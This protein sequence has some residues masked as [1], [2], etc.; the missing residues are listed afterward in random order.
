MGVNVV[1]REGISFSHPARFML[2]GTMNPEEGDLRPQLLDRFALCVDMHGIADPRQRVA[3]V[4]RRVAYESDPEGFYGEWLPHEEQISDEIAQARAALKHVTYTQRDLYTIAQLT[5]SFKVDGHRADIVILKTGP[6]PRGLAGPAGDRRA[7][8]PAGGRAGAAASPQAPTV[9][10]GGARCRPARRPAEEGPRRSAAQQSAP[11]RQPGTDLGIRKKS[12]EPLAEPSDASASGEPQEQDAGQAQASNTGP[13]AGRQV[14]VGADFQ[15]KRLDTPLDKL[16]RK[17]AGKRS[18]TLTERKRGRYIRSRPMVGRPEDL[19]FDATFRT[20]A[21]FQRR[22]S[23]ERAERKLAFVVKRQDFQ[24]K[25]RVRRSANLVLFVVDASWS[26]AAAE[27]M[28]AT[29]GAILS[30]LHDAYQRRDQVGLVVF[31][32]EE[33]RVV[34]APTS[35]VELAQQH[36]RNIPVGGKTPLS[37]GLLAAYRVCIASQRR[38]P[39]IAPVDHHPDRR[40]RQRLRHR[41]AAAAGGGQGRADDAR[42]PSAHGRHQ[43]GASRV[44]SRPGARAGER[45]GRPLLHAAGAEGRDTGADGAPGVEQQTGRGVGTARFCLT[46]CNRQPSTRRHPGRVRIRSAAVAA[47]A[48][49]S[50]RATERKQAH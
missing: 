34:L 40:R 21:P 25:V 41:D 43:H 29:K 23:S 31:Q 48:E 27:R 45:P 2:V 50:S 26:M 38:N 9:R 47:P 18:F 35:S 7:G 16:T 28:E 32:R 39:E 33:A 15:A 12:V 36:L 42:Q 5:T 24:K 1:E 11:A 44:R 17:T 4:E 37:A 22:R 3:I 8:H 49:E 46:R 30:L 20:A 13:Q 6:R 19:A 10:G 14:K